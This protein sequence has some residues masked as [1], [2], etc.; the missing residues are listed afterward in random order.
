MNNNILYKYNIL[1]VRYHVI[2]QGKEQVVAIDHKTMLF[3]VMQALGAKE[4]PVFK[5]IECGE[6][7]V[8]VAIKLVVSSAK[9]SVGQKITTAV[10]EGDPNG[11]N[12]LAEKSALLKAM[13]HLSD[14]H[15]IK[16]LDYS[17]RVANG[18]E[19]NSIFGDVNAALYSVEK[20]IG[21]WEANIG[22]CKQLSLKLEG[23]GS[24]QAGDRE[25][26]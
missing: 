23:K 13:K 21:Q 19:S 26:Y 16:V 22:K 2:K 4:M 3:K 6:Q 14:K 1:N 17:S 24:D 25:V 15:L 9:Y 12:V 7:G 11:P 5:V 18:I 8:K 20:L 10:V